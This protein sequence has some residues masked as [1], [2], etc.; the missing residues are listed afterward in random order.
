MIMNLTYPDNMNFKKG[1]VRFAFHTCAQVVQRVL[2]PSSGAFSICYRETLSRKLTQ[3]A[4]V[5]KHC[6]L[7]ERSSAVKVKLPLF[8]AV[9]T[10]VIAPQSVLTTTVDEGE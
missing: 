3:G 7:I 5:L 2:L 1:M 4:Y 9:R 8:Y 10:L 6:I